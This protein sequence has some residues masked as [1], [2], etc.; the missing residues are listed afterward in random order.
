MADFDNFTL[1]GE[2]EEYTPFPAFTFNIP[3]ST[4]EYV[5]PPT[6]APDPYI[7]RMSEEEEKE[8]DA[9]LDAKDEYT[10]KKELAVKEPSEYMHIDSRYVGPELPGEGDFHMIITDLPEGTTEEE[11][12]DYAP[13]LLLNEINVDESE[14]SFFKRLKEVCP[15]IREVKVT[16]KAFDNAIEEIEVLFV[17]D[18]Y[19][20]ANLYTHAFIIA[21]I[22]GTIVHRF[23][24]TFFTRHPELQKTREFKVQVG[25][26]AVFKKL[27]KEVLKGGF[28]RALPG[29][30]EYL[31]FFKESLLMQDGLPVKFCTPDAAFRCAANTTID[32]INNCLDARNVPN[33]DSSWRYASLKSATIKLFC[34]EVP[35]QTGK[36]YCK[37]P[38]RIANKKACINPNCESGCFWWAVK[39]GLIL[40]REAKIDYTRKES[41]IRKEVHETSKVHTQ[42]QTISNVKKKFEELKLELTQG[43]LPE[44]VPFDPKY[45]EKF[46]QLNPRIFLSVFA[47]S[48]GTTVPVQ[49]VF[50]GNASLANES[51]KILF[52]GRKGETG[53]YVAIKNFNK[54]LY[55]VDKCKRKK[56][57]YCDI[58]KDYKLANSEPCKHL[59]MKRKFEDFDVFL[60]E[61]CMGSFESATDLE[62]HNHMCLI[63][64]K[65]YRII[66]LPEER[67]YLTFDPKKTNN[68]TPIPTYM[69]A[70]FES[71]LEPPKDGEDED[72]GTKSHVTA[73]HLPCAY[74]IKVVS[75]YPELETFT[76]YWGKDPEDTMRNFC[77][78]ILNISHRVYLA[79]CQKNPMI[80]TDYDL[81]EFNMAEQC[82]I[83]GKKFANQSEKYRD[84]D[85]VS[86]K[87][88]GAACNGCNFRRVLK[89]CDLPLVFHNAKG[90]DLHHIIKEITKTRYGC[91][92][93]GIAQNSE[94]IMSFTIMKKYNFHPDGR[95]TQEKCM[96]N[97]KII[98]SLLFLLKSLETLTGI[99]KKRH[100]DELE[101]AFPI[102]YKTM[103]EDGYSDEQI[104]ASL[105]KNLYPYLWFDSFEKISA[106]LDEIIKLVRG[107]E[108]SFFT[109]CV[110]E[111]YKSTFAKKSEVFFN[112]LEKF[113]EFKT[114]YD[115]ADLYLSCDVL[116]LADIIEN[117]RKTF[118][119]THKLD[120]L[121]YYGAPGYSWDAFLL[122]LRQRTSYRPDLFIA[123]EMNMVC[124]FMQCI[125][126][127]CSGIMKRFAQANTPMIQSTYDP[128]KPKRYIMYLDANN[129]YGWSMMQDLPYKNFKWFSTS[130]LAEFNSGGQP[131]MEK[132]FSML[133]LKKKGFF[134]EVKLLYPRELHDAHNLY[135]LAP[136]RRCVKENEVSYFTRHLHNKLKVKI[137]TKTPLL[138]QTLEDKDHYFIY[139]KNLELYLQLGLKLAHV[140]GGIYFDEAPVMRG[141]INLNTVLRNQPDAS[142][143]ERELYKLLN[144]S[145]YGKTLENPLKYSLL[146]FISTK[147][148]FDKAAAKP[149]FDGT[150]FSQDDFAIAKLKYETIKYDKPLYL[151][152]TVTELAKWKMFNFYY[153]VI[154]DYFKNP[155][156]LF[157]DT[158][159]LMIEFESEDIFLDIAMINRIEKY[160]CPIDVSTFDKRIIE[161]Y[162]IPTRNNKVIGAFKSETGSELIAEFVGLRAKMYSYI[163]NGDETAKHLRAKGVARSSLNMI[164]H[165]NYIQCLFNPDVPELARQPIKMNSIRSKQHNL[166][167][168]ESEKFGLSCNDTKR[169]IIPTGEN[170]F[171]ETLAFGHYAIPKY[172]GTEKE[173]PPIPPV[174]SPTIPLPIILPSSSSSPVSPTQDLPTKKKNGRPIKYNIGNIYN[175]ELN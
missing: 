120:L 70:D 163:I 7:P 149:G 61:K 106:P 105:N 128:S 52:L 161:K 92:F 33:M 98:D 72:N 159:S 122:Y 117:A 12:E 20:D 10:H 153:N 15:T 57:I 173:S 164:S 32:V 144:N 25:F 125:R 157:T 63:I 29:N 73:N 94:K 68:L 91:T 39:I 102:M 156:L 108:Y 66:E 130:E 77:E 169:Y 69:V 55:N 162:R 121:R 74:G 34:Y 71:I 38:P 152:A 84:H 79:Y 30:Y 40:N 126:G 47:E 82:Y 89:N 104:E 41:E 36:G 85:H 95:A 150:V 134:M 93:N 143:F 97:I 119:T 62:M 45:Y 99:L 151:G 174:P 160:D 54:F 118:F 11:A 90:Y 37:L 133:K 13:R 96:C 5:D 48:E 26:C 83:C 9:I 49:L 147:K 103:R 75:I 44:N 139:W 43:D 148:Q 172:E 28:V 56:K 59:K 115:Y 31:T 146:H 123:S 168:I 76:T 42:Y 53:H 8:L 3:T 87:Y 35:F 27:K 154:C 65:N 101:K 1:D 60:C 142:D 86:G 109:D 112:V 19:K 23:I 22:V 100:P 132:Y 16:S 50:E 18:V 24:D 67:Q 138:L 58:C 51:V 165:Q 88:L 135:P 14:E 140:Y 64:D 167:S 124:F 171:I 4:V 107:N 17:R 116:Q 110:D 6:V 127:G 145:I 113:P 46:C 114:V 170:K 80:F 175:G 129:L 81:D 111:T 158:D 141:Y 78:D 2:D 21:S 137:N 136:E 155:K 131:F 166:M